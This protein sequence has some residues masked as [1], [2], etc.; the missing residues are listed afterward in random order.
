MSLLEWKDEYEVG[1]ASVDYEHQELIASINDLYQAMQTRATAEL[2]IDALGKIYAQI[3]AH[4]A[5]E[6]KIMREANYSSY[7]EHKRDHERLLDELLETMDSVEGGNGYVVSELSSTL[8]EWFSNHFR[9]HDAR[10]HRL[11]G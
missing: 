3:S 1:V 4:F 6:E 2:V 11:L 7:A 8:D 9:T 10:L 5:L